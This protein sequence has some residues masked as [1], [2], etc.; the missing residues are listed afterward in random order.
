MR[1]AAIAASLVA[2]ALI[3]S[4]CGS[5]GSGEQG[6]KTKLTIATFGD[7][8]YKDLYTEYMKLHPDIEV[9][10]RITK[11]ED[12]HKNLITHLAANSG[13]SDIEAIEEGW[14]GQF[15]SQPGKFYNWMD[16]GGGDVKAQWPEWKWRAGSSASGVVIGLGTDVGGMAMCYRKDLFEKAGLP[17]D[18][19]AVSKLWPTWDDYISTG[20]K[21]MGAKLPGVTG[22]FDG[23]QVIY[24]SVLG[25]QPIGIYDGDKVVVDT[26][27]GVKKA[28]DTTVKAMTVGLSAKVEAW[29]QDWNAGFAKG[30]FATIACPSWMTTIIQ[31]QAKEHAGKWDIAD[32]PGGTGNW[33]GSYLTL[34]K[35]G[36][37]AKA[38]AELAKW[39]TAPEQQAKVFRTKGNFPSTVTLYKDAVITDYKSAF[40][41]NA[42]IGQIYSKSV[43]TMVPQFMGPKSGDINTAIING[44]TRVQDG[45]QGAD[46]S[47]A[48]VQKDVKALL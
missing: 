42:P 5:G 31:E 2:A 24:R 25:Q 32:I 7:F 47:W 15:T 20:Q 14:A 13:A 23:P 21:F 17:G 11:T 16:Y 43:A 45:K 30:T 48:Q 9:V 6:G 34:P 28:W 18:R 37:N 41:N 36:K 44:L 12:H 3:A 26:N 33:G 35:Q 38:A 39:L 19:E 29:S 4:G 8:G 22:F 46:D 40:F 10:E 27:P 1:K